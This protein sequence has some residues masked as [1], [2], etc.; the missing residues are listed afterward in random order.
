MKKYRAEKVAHLNPKS[1]DEPKKRAYKKRAYEKI[2]S[3][4][5]TE[6]K[7]REMEQLVIALSLE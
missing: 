5:S 2:S 4:I 7:R 1:S 6:E 3:K